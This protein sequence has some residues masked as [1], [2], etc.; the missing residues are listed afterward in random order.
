L[1]GTTRS[2][3]EVAPVVQHLAHAAIGL[4]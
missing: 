4:S 3:E 2:L 1:A